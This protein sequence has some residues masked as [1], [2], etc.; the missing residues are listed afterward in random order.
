MEA[1]NAKTD[2]NISLNYQGYDSMEE[3]I[4]AA[5]KHEN[6]DTNLI[7]DGY[8]TFGELYDHRIS[9]FI[10]LCRVVT[11]AKTQLLFTELNTHK[12]WKSLRHSDG[13]LAYGGRWFVLGL[14]TNKGSQV[15]YHIP[16]SRWEE[17]RFIP[18]LERAPEWDGHTPADVLERLNKI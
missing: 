13:E 8:H 16:L 5:I 11:A 9:L 2:N 7:S 1:S 15:T 12:V 18:E 4:N 10:T 17:C 6:V 14:G 3:L